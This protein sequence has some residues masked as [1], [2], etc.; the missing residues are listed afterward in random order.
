MK[1]GPMKRGFGGGAGRKAAGLAFVGGAAFVGARGGGI[2]FIGAR[3]A[4]FVCRGAAFAGGA[5]AFGGVRGAGA[6]FVGGAEGD[7][8][9]L[10]GLFFA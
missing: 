10:P 7:R 6:A 9:R 1:R 8:S 2:A 3:G 5:A 4:A